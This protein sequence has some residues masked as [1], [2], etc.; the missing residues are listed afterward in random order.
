MQKISKH[1]ITVNVQ[2]LLEILVTQ[3]VV[4]FGFFGCSI[5]LP[6]V[7]QHQMTFYGVHYVSLRIEF[8]SLDKQIMIIIIKVAKQY[9]LFEIIFGK[10]IFNYLGA[11]E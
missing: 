3:I 2:R 11:N 5:P 6:Y 9:R 8:D 1:V 10:T 7:L 4:E